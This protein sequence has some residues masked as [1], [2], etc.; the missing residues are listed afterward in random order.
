MI[1]E[2]VNR[3]DENRANLRETFRINFPDTYLE[4]VS[5]VIKVVTNP[6]DYEY[7]NPD[8]DRIT[9][10]DHG[11]YQGTLLFIIAAKG[12][13]P[14]RFWSVFVSYG[15]CSGCDT[16]Q[17]IHSAIPYDDDYVNQIPND[18]NID[19]IMTLALHIVQRLKLIGEE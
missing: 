5:E 6:N 7:D 8:P 15:S 1:Q 17:S 14:S 9:V 2:F 18:Q 19:D 11:D 4:I 16:L 12:Y 13:Q 3:F 10:I